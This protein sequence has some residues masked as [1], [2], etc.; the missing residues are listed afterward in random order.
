MNSNDL[1]NIVT[2]FTLYKFLDTL[3]MPFIQTDAYRLGIIDAKGNVLKDVQHLNP[4]EKFAYNEF[5]QLVFSLKRLLLKV[6]DP[7]V[8]SSL[9]NVTS[10][11]RLI[12]EHCEMVGGDKELFVELALRELDACRLIS[13]EGEGGGAVAS[14]GAPTMSVGGG[15]IYGLKPE[16]TTFLSREA[17]KRHTSNNSIFRRKKPNKYYMDQDKF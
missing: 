16:E 10:A 4:T 7:Y 11:L 3:T 6:P 14:S 9:T 17:Q 5:Y 12:S 13:E 2:S 15:G 8:R 1:K